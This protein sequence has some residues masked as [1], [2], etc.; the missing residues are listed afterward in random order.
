MLVTMRADGPVIANLLLDGI[1]GADVHTLAMR[2]L[3]YALDH[4][5]TTE[6]QPVVGARFSEGEQRFTLHNEADRP[7][8]IRGRFPAGEHFVASPAEIERTLASG[9][10]ESVGVRLRAARPVPVAQLTPSLAHWTVEAQGDLH[11]MQAESTSWLIPD[12]LFSVRP[13]A[14]V[15]VDA[16]LREW[17]PLRFALEHWPIPEGGTASASLRFDVRRD[18]DFV[19]LAFD[20][21]DR[22]RAVSSERTA[23]DQDGVTVELD[24]RPDPARSSN[25]GVQPSIADGTLQ[26]LLITALTVVEPL[27]DPRLARVLAP[28]PDGLRRAVREREGGYTAE[29]AVPCRYLD[30][31]AGGSWE[32]FRLNVILQDYALDGSGHSHEWRP[33]RFGAPNGTIRGAGTF[34]RME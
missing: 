3:M 10:R 22:T 19:Y 29:L 24:A 27:P 4:A 9:A 2:N 23:E 5:V 14:T 33:S 25:Q 8:T 26:S 6:P 20:V 1:H 28:P 21:R 11:P 12:R 34:V 32:R 31:R 17:A 16:D 13:A 7:I 18:R 30:E 15:A